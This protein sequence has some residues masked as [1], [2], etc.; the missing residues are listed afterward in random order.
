MDRIA[1]E[2]FGP[3]AFDPSIEHPPIDTALL[4]RRPLT[5]KFRHRNP[6]TPPLETSTGMGMGLPDEETDISPFDAERA[7]LLERLRYNHK[8][9]KTKL[10]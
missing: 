9:V 7:Q 5:Q 3:S 4:S 8:N 2:V 10:F 6:S 1:L